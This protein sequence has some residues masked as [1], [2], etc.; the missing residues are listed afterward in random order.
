M[1][2]FVDELA[3]YVLVYL[4]A[5]VGCGV[6]VGR[7][8]QVEDPETRTG[9]LGLL[10]GSGGWALFQTAFLVAP[11]YR[12]AYLSYIASLVI[13]LS[14]IY[15]WLY[16]ASAFTGRTLHRS[17][18]WRR[19]AVGSYLAIIVL[20]LTNPLHGSYFTIT[21]VAEPFVHYEITHGVSH[22]VIT[23]V[24]YVAAGIGFFMLFEAF[25]EADYDTLPLA[26]L[27]VLTAAPVGLDV[28]GYT[29]DVFIEM[30]YEPIG[31]AVFAVGALFVFRDRFFVVQAS[32]TTQKPLLYF[33]A[34]DRLRDYNSH[35]EAVYPDVDARCGERLS[36]AFP[37]IAAALD[38]ETATIRR[39]EGDE[40]GYYLVTE[41][42]VS[43]TGPSDGR[44][45]HLTD[46]TSA[47]RRRRELDRHN[48]QLESISAGLRHELLNQLNILQGWIRQTE[49]AVVDG[50]TESAEEALETVDDAGDRAVD[51]IEDFVSLTQY[52]TTVDETS[53][54]SLESVVA[55]ARTATDADVSLLATVDETV[56]ANRSR[57]VHMVT[58]AVEFAAANGAGSLAV[59][60][61]DGQITFTDDGEPI[62]DETN[63]G[64]YF[65]LD[66]AVPKSRAGLALPKVR[67][68]AQLHGWTV[69]LDEGYEAGIKI[70]V[71][72]SGVGG[73]P[74]VSTP[75]ASAAGQPTADPQS[76]RSADATADR[77]SSDRATSDAT[78]GREGQSV[79]DAVVPDG[80][81]QQARGQPSD[82]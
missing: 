38:T 53:Q 78:P 9:L 15:A 73:S 50:D 79:V 24:S 70:V 69:Q 1:I 75:A 11:T 3:V 2:G 68:L 35:A 32:D 5:T 37:A 12:V 34:N 80:L 6:G 45:I 17:R 31:V 27:S 67:V 26:G 40:P 14:S 74:V 19:V 49:R 46:V 52:G 71:A 36:T 72:G 4:L 76:A 48:Q 43:Q 33:D 10:L 28:L 77:S 64:D 39:D 16:F 65:D 66:A 59:G 29:T 62:G 20:K 23:G 13:G 82:D 7:A 8:L 22:W 55:E 54:V 30:N 51:I 41:T 63:P 58:S 56:A 44:V 47:E 60:V 25:T 81:W 42:F 57:L 21:W 18:I 61:T